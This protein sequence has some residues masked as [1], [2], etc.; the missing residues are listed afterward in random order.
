MRVLD[1]TNRN[2]AVIWWLGEKR[3]AAKR[4]VATVGDNRGHGDALV[5]ISIW[6]ASNRKPLLAVWC[7][8]R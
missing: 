7:P 3:M 5:P 1:C 8:E 6:P 2:A 4:A